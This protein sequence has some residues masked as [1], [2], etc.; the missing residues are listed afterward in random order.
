MAQTS[1]SRI[2]KY[3]PMGGGFRAPLNA[4]IP[5][6]DVGKIRGVSI[7][8]SGRAVLGGAVVAIKGVICAVKVMAAGDIIDVMTDGEIVQ[9]TLPAGTALVAGTDYYADATT[10][11]LTATATSNAYVGHTVELDRLVVRVGR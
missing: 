3:E 2:D 11:A 7:N 9:A 8:S 10:G 1:F 6:D 4:A 5:A